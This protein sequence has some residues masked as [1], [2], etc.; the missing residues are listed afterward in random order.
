MGDRE[1]FRAAMEQ[2]SRMYLDEH[3]S[4]VLDRKDASYVQMIRMGSGGLE[5]V[6]EELP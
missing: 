5:A 6:T 3:F 2:A 1:D 4:P